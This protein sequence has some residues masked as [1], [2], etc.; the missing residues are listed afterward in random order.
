[1]ADTDKE[2]HWQTPEE[3]VFVLDDILQ[4]RDEFGNILRFRFLRF[5]DNIPSS[6]RFEVIYRDTDE[7]SIEIETKYIEWFKNIANGN[8]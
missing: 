8:K 7:R 1:M 3:I 4:I 6:V 5:E 2:E